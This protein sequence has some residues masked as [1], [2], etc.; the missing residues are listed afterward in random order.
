MKLFFLLLF[1]LLAQAREIVLFQPNGQP[2]ANYNELVDVKN[3]KVGDEFVFAD[4]SKFELTRSLGKGGTT[5]VYAVKPVAP[6]SGNGQEF[7]L[8]L[9]SHSGDVLSRTNAKVSTA[10]FLKE[11]VEGF[12]PLKEAGVRFPS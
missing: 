8:R 5:R 10:E 9:R 11:T 7:A 4:G 3:L 6:T 2:V 12:R 1:S